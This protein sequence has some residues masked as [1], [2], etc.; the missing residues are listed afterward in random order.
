[1]QCTHIELSI[2][3]LEI[4]HISSADSTREMWEQLTTVKES[5]GR[6]RVLVTWQTLY[7]MMAEKGFDMV[8][9]ISS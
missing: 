4:I 3:D 1:M 6:L 2:D 7:Q 8:E 9:H 5:K